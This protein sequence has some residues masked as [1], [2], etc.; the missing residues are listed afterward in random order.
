MAYSFLEKIS[1]I[2]R[3]PAETFRD[4]RDEHPAAALVHY[5]KLALV[6][7]VLMPFTLYAISGLPTTRKWAMATEIV[8]PLDL[9]A[10]L[11]VTLIAAPL[12]AGVWLHI[13][14][15]I[16]GGRGGIGQTFKTA[17]YACTSLLAIG[18][19]PIIGLF[20]G[21]FSALYNQV[22]GIRELHHLSS[23]RAIGAVCTATFLPAVA[24]IGL[25]IMVVTAPAATLS[26]L[27]V[28]AGSPPAPDYPYLLNATE[29]PGNVAYHSASEVRADI[30]P[31]DARY[32]GCLKEYTATYADEKP[33]TA[34]SRRI[35]QRAM[36][37]PP[38]GNASAM[39]QRDEAFYRGLVPPR[40]AEELP[41]PDLGD[42]CISYRSP[43]VGSD[44]NNTYSAY[45]IIFTSGD[46]YEKFITIGPDPDY[47]LLTELAERAAAKVS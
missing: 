18:W 17:M 6:F 26:A 5:L 16:F 37:F 24:F 12:V 33:S 43:G 21:A 2:L 31:W 32:L 20:G 28:E 19:V 36:V 44:A 42:R 39:L 46:V 47:E 25:A 30:I 35:T 7:S 10:V 11:L 13:W 34:T 29:I 8:H 41:A 45:S 1:G 15:Y 4:L 40:N 23:R 22:V 14:V 27:G 38:G 9:F 3:R